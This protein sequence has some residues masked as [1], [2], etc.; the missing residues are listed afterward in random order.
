MGTQMSRTSENQPIPINRNKRKLKIEIVRSIRRDWMSDPR[1][2]RN[3]LGK[4]YGVSISTIEAIIRH[5]IWKD[6]A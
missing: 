4:K 2:N 3:S 5:K 1:P 6:V